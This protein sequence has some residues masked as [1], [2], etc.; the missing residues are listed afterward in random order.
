MTETAVQIPLWCDE[1]SRY[2]TNAPFVKN[3]WLYATDLCRAIRVPAVGEQDSPV[4]EKPFPDTESAFKDFSKPTEW[5]PWPDVST[6]IEGDVE[7]P[8][9]EG[10]GTIGQVECGDCKGSGEVECHACGSIDECDECDGHGMAGGTKCLRCDGKCKIPGRDKI[11]C[12]GVWISGKFDEAVRL[13]QNPV[14]VAPNKD[15]VFIRFDG[16]EAII[17]GLN[18]G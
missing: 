11:N 7:C 6:A 10:Y 4:G 18:V 13:L 12:G 5:Q 14:F 2:S 1:S 15:M 9:C 17:M 3:G 8:D 16:G